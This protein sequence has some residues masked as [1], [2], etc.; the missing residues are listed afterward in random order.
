MVVKEKITQ[1]SWVILYDNMLNEKHILEAGEKGIQLKDE[2][3]SIFLNYL[4]VINGKLFFNLNDDSNSGHITAFRKINR[5]YEVKLVF[6]SKETGTLTI[7]KGETVLKEVENVPVKDFL[8]AENNG[9][10]FSKANFIYSAGG[11]VYA[12]KLQTK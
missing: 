8:E 2:N 5:G 1:K 6:N 3:V 12:E 7:S 11:V 9:I 4:L 10:T